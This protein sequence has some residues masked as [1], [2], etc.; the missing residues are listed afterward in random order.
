MVTTDQFVG[1][2]AQMNEIVKR[3]GN[4]SLEP[5]LVKRSL[6][7]I[8]EDR[9]EGNVLPSWY[10]VPSLQLDRVRQLNAERDWGFADAHFPAVPSVKQS[11]TEVLL[12]AVYLPGKDGAWDV[13]RTFNEHLAV[14]QQQQDASGRTFCP[15]VKSDRKHLR[16]FS[17]TWHEPRPGLR[18]VLYDYAFSHDPANGIAVKDLWYDEQRGLAASEVLTALMLFPEYGLSMGDRK[19]PYANL[20]G[21]QVL[22]DADWSNVPY[23][24]RFGSHLR[25][26]AD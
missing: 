10:V 7:T 25:L 24:Y 26:D 12:L 17:P 21:Y 22:V 16:R 5:D 14:I 4:G 23:L 6:Q 18:W 19:T 3:V 9:T 11:G 20:P 2:H 13:Q 8:I 15:Y 1:L